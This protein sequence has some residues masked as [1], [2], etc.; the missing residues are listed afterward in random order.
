[1]T[2]RVQVMGVPAIDTTEKSLEVDGKTLADVRDELLRCEADSLEKDQLAVAF[3]NGEAAGEDWR[4]V[5][6]STDS[7]VLFVVPVSG[8]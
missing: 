3:V 6:V 7:S 5:P 8:G 1:M 2:V 4:E